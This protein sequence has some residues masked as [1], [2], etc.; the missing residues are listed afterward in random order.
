[1]APRT[2]TKQP[3]AARAA[4]GSPGA[5]WPSATS[6]AAADER[7][8]DHRRDP[9]GTGDRDAELERVLSYVDAELEHYRNGQRSEPIDL[10]VEAARI[11]ERQS[12]GTHRARESLAG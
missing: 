5:A 2:K 12:A 3:P 11:H 10:I 1:V 6:D 9:H 4:A 8:R 7:V